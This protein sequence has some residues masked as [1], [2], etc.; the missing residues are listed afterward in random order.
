MSRPSTNLVA[1]AAAA[2]ALVGPPAGVLGAAAVAASQ[3]TT[4]TLLLGCS[5]GGPGGGTQQIDRSVLDADAMDIARTIVDVV[6]QR[7]LPRRAAVLAVAT[8]LVESGLRNLD[9]GDRDS[10]GVF[11]QRPSQG[12]GTRAQILDPVHA[13]NSFLD[14]LIVIPGWATMRPGAAEQA[15]Q[16]S[17]FPERYAPREQQAADI[18]T[19]FW[20]G[21]DNPTPPP[22]GGTEPVAATPSCPDHGASDLPCRPAGSTR[23]S[24]RPGSRSRRTRARPPQCR[25]RWRSWESPTCGAGKARTPMTA[26]G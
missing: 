12:W 13:T 16:R 18:V 3:A 19:K 22:A 7:V 26:P 2:V 4:G 21:P 9:Y 24:S 25:S 6:R 14:H 1:I 8:G 23:T 17:G 10:L 15:V 11:Q 20:T 5:D